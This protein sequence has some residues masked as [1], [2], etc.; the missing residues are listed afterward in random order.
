[1]R[2]EEAASELKEVPQ[3]GN[4][5]SLLN[6]SANYL[7]Q[8]TDP[9]YLAGKLEKRL[10]SES[11]S[12]SLR[13]VTDLYPRAKNQRALNAKLQGS[14]LGDAAPDDGESTTAWI[15]KNKKMQKQRAR[16]IELAKQRER[17]QEEMDRGVYGEGVSAREAWRSRG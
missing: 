7:T 13:T 6:R 1:V 16:E 3:K 5:H 10:P 8:R 17:E 14:T 2:S 12:A 15:K 9:R 11:P 4:V